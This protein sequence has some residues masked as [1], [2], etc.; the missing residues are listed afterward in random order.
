VLKGAVADQLKGK[1][2]AVAA[3]MEAVELGR[4][5]AAQHFDCPLP[6][7]VRHAEAPRARSSCPA[8]TRRARRHLCRRHRVRLVSDHSVTSL[9]RAFEK[10]AK[11]LRVTKDGR[12]LF[13][14]VQART[15]WRRSA[16]PLAA[17][18]TARAR[19]RPPRGPASRS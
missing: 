4:A 15:S 6:I 9:G 11:R 16:L 18:G 1:E 7:H 14:I 5:Y 10:Y 3:N 8:T 12:R 19:S 17:G 13:G 2:K